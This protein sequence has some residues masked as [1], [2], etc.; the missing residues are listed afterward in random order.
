MIENGLCTGAGWREDGLY[1][2]LREGEE[3]L[4]HPVRLGSRFAYEISAEPRCIGYRAPGASSLEP[5]PDR[6]EGASQ[7]PEC[8]K[9]AVILPCLRCDGSRCRNPERR[10][11]CVR[12]LNH[13]LY[14]AAFSMTTLKVGVARWERRAQRVSEQSARAALIIART[15]GQTVRRWEQMIRSSG[16]PDRIQPKEKLAALIDDDPTVDLIAELKKKSESLKRRLP[17]E[18]LS[19]VEEISPERIG[20][21]SNPRLTHPSSLG[22][23]SGEVT[24]VIGEL[25]TISS[26]LGEEI[27]IEARALT[28]HSMRP[29]EIGDTAEGQLALSSILTPDAVEAG[30]IDEIPQPDEVPEDILMMV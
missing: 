23:I 3:K 1:L 9:R 4:L 17:I 29:F 19:T 7:C 21:I 24:A 6:S 2:E 25:I 11:S 16:V 30:V 8:F 12:P 27:S 14:L 26:D 10:D 20:S 28:G 18:W 5:C 22:Q 13:A 15:D